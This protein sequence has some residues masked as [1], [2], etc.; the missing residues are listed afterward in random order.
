MTNTKVSI[1]SRALVLLGDRPISSFDEGTTGADI[2]TSLYESSYETLLT[3]TRW[4]F[5]QKTAQL[6]RF[7]A[8]PDTGYR[9]KFSIPSDLLYLSKCSSYDYEI[10]DNELHSN[11][12]DVWADYTHRVDEANLP[13]YYVKALEFYLAMQFAIPLTGNTSRAQEFMAFFER[14]VKIARYNDSSQRPNDSI[15]DSPYITARMR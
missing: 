1:A 11:D 9:Y 4:R 12:I 10:Y 14:Q 5:A 13:A 8:A 6:S 7:V 3:E 2:A 15:E